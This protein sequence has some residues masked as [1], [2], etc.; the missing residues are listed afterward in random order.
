M[1]A[2]E[3]AVAAEAMLRR[4]ASRLPH[5][6]PARVEHRLSVRRRVDVAAINGRIIGCEIK[7]A[8]DNFGRLP[9]QVELVQRRPRY[10]SACC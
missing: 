8:R 1:R 10:R 6:V 7:S 2:G 9:S 5:G 3:I 4:A